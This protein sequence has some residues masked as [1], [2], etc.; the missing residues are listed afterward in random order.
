MRNS[1]IQRG[2]LLLVLATACGGDPVMAPVPVVQT[3][4]R[5]VEYAR[6][7]RNPLKGFTNR[8][9]SEQNEWASLVHS[10]IR[11]NEIED[12]EGDGIDRIQAW[13]D[14][15]WQGLAQRN[16]KVIPR[17]YLHWSGDLKYW[18]ADMVEDDY[19]SPQFEQRVLRLI[20]RLG[21]V[22]DSD[23]R[24][25]H[26]E[27]GL[28]GKWGEHH[29]PG[30]DETM[31]QLL[32]NAFRA[33]FVHKQVL[34]RHPWEFVDFGFGIYW[35][36]W[37]HANQANHADG[38]FA[39]GDRWQTRIMGGEVAYDWGDSGIQPGDSP[40]DTV[41]DP[42]HRQ[43]L[44]DTVRRLHATQL[45][46]VADYDETDDAAFTGG[47]L[48]QKAFGYRFVFDEVRFSY[49]AA[50]VG[51][52]AGSLSVSFTVRNTGSAPFYRDWPVEVT[53]LDPGTRR[54]VWSDRF[55][56]VDIRGWLPG[57]GWDAGARRYTSDEPTY[58]ETGAFPLPQD[59]APGSYILALA[60]LDPD[61]MLPAVR[62]AIDNYHSGGRH[63][64][65][66]IGIGVGVAVDE[67]ELPAASFDDPHTD[68]T[69]HYIY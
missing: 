52:A 67:A 6:A 27:M 10:Y 34:V 63:P 43:H 46:W 31:Q 68:Q 40:T 23:S 26:V 33:A 14:H 37:A 57:D 29:S 44:I 15:R 54:V 45:R 21:Q 58:V 42:V 61:G 20:E 48:V 24:V 12:D 53:L 30:P 38:I 25:A 7:L 62:F 32:G 11:W 1:I 5:P 2:V 55:A 17:V 13:C 18:P 35:D 59:L 56:D 16:I 47:E 8:G 28:I 51:D 50:T 19:S 60:I 66:M 49:T 65:G 3:V 69:L 4:I 9:F 22:W 39:L 64:I 36:S 41:S